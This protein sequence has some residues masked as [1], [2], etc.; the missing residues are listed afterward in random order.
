[1]VCETKRLIRS[2]RQQRCRRRNRRKMNN[3]KER[4]K[5]YKRKQRKSKK[6]RIN[7]AWREILRRS[8]EIVRD[9]PQEHAYL[10]KTGVQNGI[11]VN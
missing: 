5:R 9:E 10:N 6:L 4:R 11:R 7:E 2:Y 3:K 8:E 1:M